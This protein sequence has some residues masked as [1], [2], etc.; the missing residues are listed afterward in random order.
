MHMVL[1]SHRRFRPARMKGADNAEK[2]NKSNNKQLQEANFHFIR[3][4]L[5][6]TSFFSPYCIDCHFQVIMLLPAA[7]LRTTG[8]FS[9]CSW[10]DRG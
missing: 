2:C 7:A 8:Y 4:H 9:D 10:V 1:L 5:C 3:H 6:C